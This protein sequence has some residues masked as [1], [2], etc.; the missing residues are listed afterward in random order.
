MGKHNTSYDLLGL[1]PGSWNLP[2]A[3][4][5]PAKAQRTGQPKVQAL[6]HMSGAT[7]VWF[8]LEQ[9]CEFSTWVIT[10]SRD[11]LPQARPSC[12]G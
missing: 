5:R 12:S 11:L 2:T 4:L 10:A 7:G 9:L 6:P 8:P 1:V 3:A